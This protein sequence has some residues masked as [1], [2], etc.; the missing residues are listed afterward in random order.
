VNLYKGWF[1]ETLPRWAQENPGPIAFMHLDADIYSSTKCV[2]D[3]LGDRIVP[4]TVL[5]FDEYFN[6]PGWQKGEYKAFNEFVEAHQ[7]KFEYL[8]YAKNQV[9]VR[10]LEIAEPKN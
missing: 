7:V 6:Y 8:G 2:F 5:Q 1:N 10:I 4:G 3:I 9:A